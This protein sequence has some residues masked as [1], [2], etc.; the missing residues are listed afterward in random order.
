MLDRSS[1]ISSTTQIIEEAKQ[2]KPF[3][4][5]DGEDREN[6]GDLVI[7]AEFV[8]PENIAFMIK[9]C[10][11]I[12]CLTMTKQ[13]AESLDLK[14]MVEHNKSAFS[15]PFTVS[16]EAKHGITTGVSAVDRVTTIKTAIKDRASPNDLVSPGHIFPLVAQDGG[17]LVR[18]GHTESSVD[19][20]KLAGLSGCAVICEIMNEDGT[21]S[22]LPELSEF[23]KKHNIKIGT[24][25]DLIGYR[26]KNETFLKRTFETDLKN[27][28]KLICFAEKY[29]N[30]EHFAI[31]KG[32]IAKAVVRI[33]SFNL[34]DEISGEVQLGLLDG[35]KNKYENL[36][37]IIIN[38]GRN[39]SIAE[40]NVK[41]YGKGAE[42]LKHLG[43]MKVKLLTKKVG[44]NFAG[45]EGFGITIEDEILI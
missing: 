22:R 21:M 37:F 26:E 24:I 29:S 34:F 12:I 27:G 42:I 8:T 9:H 28:S 20:C 31:I 41:D 32:D 33:Q 2:G 1:I 43:L 30:L 35:L 19:I 45:I 6:E 44:R 39:W 11:G 5:V 18:A 23:A 16:I 3:I 13:K 7:P 14:P 40:T 10:S 17:V 36:V 25:S 4:L 38:N 15:T